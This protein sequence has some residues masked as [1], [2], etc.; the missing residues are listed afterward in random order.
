[1]FSRLAIVNLVHE[2]RGLDV[3]PKQIEKCAAAGDHETAAV[4]D[5]IHTD[6]IT[7]VA[8]GQCLSRLLLPSCSVKL[9]ASGEQDIV[10]FTDFLANLL[11]RN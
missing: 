6:E 2:A 7:H 5:I 4:L 3:N 8:V 9:T 10:P 1:M 11:R